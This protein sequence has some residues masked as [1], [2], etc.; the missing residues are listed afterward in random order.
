MSEQSHELSFEAPHLIIART[1]GNWLDTEIINSSIDGNA[2]LDSYAGFQKSLTLPFGDSQS[3]D[4]LK[5]ISHY[6]RL[7]LWTDELFSKDDS[8]EIFSKQ[9]FGIMMNISGAHRVQCLVI[10]PNQGSYN[11]HRSNNE[12]LGLSLGKCVTERLVSTHGTVPDAEAMKSQAIDKETL[13]NDTFAA[14]DLHY[15]TV[16]GF[17]SGRPLAAR[18]STWNVVYAS[19]LCA[20]RREWTNLAVDYISYG[21]QQREGDISKVPLLEPTTITRAKMI[22]P[23][24]PL[25]ADSTLTNI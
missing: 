21:A 18:R 12:D 9:L 11:I 13:I 19:R 3:V 17:F 7:R 23:F 4:T 24:E 2:P 6:Q 8:D 14:T 20:V 15:N 22:Y 16:K 5:T 10:S 1:L 25:P